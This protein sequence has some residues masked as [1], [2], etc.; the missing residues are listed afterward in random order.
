[1]PSMKEQ[2]CGWSTGWIALSD[3][4]PDFGM[5][6]LIARD[7]ER[8]ASESTGC[9]ALRATCQSHALMA[10]K[11]SVFGRHNIPDLSAMRRRDRHAAAGAD[12]LRRHQHCTKIAP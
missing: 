6:T 11:I 5:T 10:E 9:R 3:L 2:L 1:M 4:M 12:R 8:L 7:F